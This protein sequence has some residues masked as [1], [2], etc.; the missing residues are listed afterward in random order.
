MAWARVC[1]NTYTPLAAFLVDNIDILFQLTKSTAIGKIGEP[2]DIASF[3]SYIVSKEAHFITGQ[4]S[5]RCKHGLHAE[6][7]SP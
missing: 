2:E 5:S 7:I 4:S 1:W 6:D 3:V